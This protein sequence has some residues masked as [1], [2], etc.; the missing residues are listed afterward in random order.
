MGL[1]ETMD[2]EIK[3]HHRRVRYRGTHPRKFSEKYKEL[4][5]E[6]Y[7]ADV[8]RVLE[9]GRTPAGTHRPICVSE[10]VEILH[11]RPGEIGL[12]ATVGYGGHARRLLEELDHQGRL[13]AIDTDPIE[14]PK[15]EERLRKLG[16]SEELLLFRRMN[17]AGIEKLLTEAPKGF[18]FILAD[19]GVSSMQLDNP[20]RGFTFKDDGPLDLRMN[21]EGEPHQSS[22]E[23]ATGRLWKGFCGRTPTNPSGRRSPKPSS[24]Q[25]ID[26]K[27]PGS[28]PTLSLPLSPR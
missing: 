23:C 3:T 6:E 2:E 12:D 24:L 4:H 25:G 15:T 17:F 1:V 26:F 8:Q 13:L 10:I 7:A 20:S 9:R 18:D 27:G 28:W 11:P 5:P 19:L 22:S 21:P 14:L 16:F